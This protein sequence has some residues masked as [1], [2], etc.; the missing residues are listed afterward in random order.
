MQHILYLCSY[1][2]C[3][4]VALVTNRVVGR[5][6]KGRDRRRN[7]ACDRGWG[8]DFFWGGV[9]SEVVTTTKHNM[10]PSPNLCQSL[11]SVIAR[12]GKKP[13][14]CDAQLKQL[15]LN[16]HYVALYVTPHYVLSIFFFILE[17]FLL[18]VHA[19]FGIQINCYN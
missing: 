6:G 3:K 18:M 12:S 14:E 17:F 4:G 15:L 11:L 13:M 9:R 19:F 7:R 5:D 1:N 8:V 16:L 10:N 2:E